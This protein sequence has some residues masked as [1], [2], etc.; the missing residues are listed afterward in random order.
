VVIGLGCIGGSLERGETPL[1]GLQREAREEIGCALRVRGAGATLEV[2]ALGEPARR[3]WP[4]GDPAPA[5]VW[6][7]NV[8]GGVPGA[9]VAVYLGVPEG[10]P[11]PGDLAGIVTMGAD[12]MLRIGGPPWRVNCWLRPRRQE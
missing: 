10:H 4:E 9:K 7:A 2:S 11:R 1:Q 8:P 12:L 5:L 6:Q 3:E